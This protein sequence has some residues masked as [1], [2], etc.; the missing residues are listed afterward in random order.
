[1]VQRRFKRLAVSE[2]AGGPDVNRIM[3]DSLEFLILGPTEARGD[4]RPL[5]LSGPRR[6]ALVARLLLDAGRV[7]S[8]DTLIADVWGA[9]ASPASLA[10]LHSHISQLRKVLGACLETGH[11]GYALS[12][13]SA[14][15][16]A[17]QFERLAEAAASR[18]AGGDH[19][20]ALAS[21]VEAL[22]LWRGQAFQ[23]VADQP[24]A[25][26]EAA[27]LEE[28]RARS[29]EQRL[30]MLLAAGQHE[31]VTGEAEA[32]VAEQPLREQRWAIMM[33]ALYRCGRQADALNASRRLRSLLVNELGI[34]PS[35]PLVALEEAI[36]RQDLPPGPPTADLGP[37]AGKAG[38]DLR[39]G[40]LAADRRDWAS[41]CQLL[42]T[43]DRLDPLG[44]GDLELLGDAAF[45]TGEQDISIAARQRAH[46]LWLEAGQPARAAVVAFLIVGNYYVRNRPAIAAGWYHKGRRLLEDQPQGP[47]HGVLAFTGAL[48]ALANGEPE[49]AAAAAAEAQRIGRSFADA[50]VEAIGLTLHACAL[51]RLGRID[52]AQPML[53]EA[54]ATA[55]SGILGPVATGQIFCWSTQALVAVGDYARAAEWIESIEATGIS[56]F[57]GDCRVH[58]AEVLRALGQVADAEAE[59]AAARSQIQSVDLLHAGIAHYELAMIHL[60]RGDLARAEQAL[61]HAAACGAAIQPGLALLQLARG[62]AQQALEMIEA[63]LASAI[64]DPVGQIRL[65]PAA[66]Q[67]ASAARR[68]DS[69]AEMAAQLQQ[70]ASSSKPAHLPAQ[71]LSAD[72]SSEVQDLICQASRGGCG[73]AFKARSVCRPGRTGASLRRVSRRCLAQRAE[74]LRVADRY[75]VQHTVLVNRV[76]PQAGQRWRVGVD[77][78][79]LFSLTGQPVNVVR[80]EA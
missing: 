63:A 33:L 5:A 29:V 7:V 20:S 15:L 37:A 57:P 66:I 1:M 75:P 64:H 25:Q 80:P 12:L 11:A 59:A 44:V 41:A 10:T 31:L 23:E 60:T 72:L 70:L 30:R 16:D 61:G 24:W 3:A 22:A 17:A 49:S 56:G 55:S 68:A 79:A 76:L 71:Q 47:A 35:P 65:L 54:L 21:V 8:A 36:L 52:E 34:D 42:V 9:Q 45:M 32:A 77:G 26:P 58:R 48:I 50:D 13:D 46:H 6:R 38:R 74:L 28:L 73:R 67:I 4:G 2:L 19:H 40:R 51:T 53:D 43:A 14:G 18:L 27:R 78:D 39:E 69:A 62:D